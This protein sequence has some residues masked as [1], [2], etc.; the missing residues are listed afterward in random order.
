MK[1][2]EIDAR[3]TQE[4]VS[5]IAMGYTISTETM[6]GSQ[7]EITKI[8][9]VKGNDFIRILLEKRTDWDIHTDK[10]VME[11]GRIPEDKRGYTIWNQHMEVIRT[12][13]WYELG[14]RDYFADRA[15]AS[16]AMAKQYARWR[17][18]EDERYSKKVELNLEKAARIVKPFVNRQNGCKSAK[19]ANIKKVYK[20]ITREGKVSYHI[21]TR[22]HSFTLA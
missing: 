2:A 5:Y 3:F 18:R 21:E 4:V 9:L 7:G 14:R 10:V 19:L 20:V 13:E 1:R 11:V 16:A 8:D 12:E 17:Q 22:R 15:T 6:K